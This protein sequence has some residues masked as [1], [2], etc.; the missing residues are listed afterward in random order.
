MRYHYEKP[1]MYSSIY[2][3]TCKCNHSVY[4][5]CTLFKI[6]DAGLAIIQQRYNPETEETYWGGQNESS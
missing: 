3:L 6:K 5:E 4:N 1:L 2:G